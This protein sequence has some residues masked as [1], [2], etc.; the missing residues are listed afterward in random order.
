MFCVLWL[1]SALFAPSAYI[2]LFAVSVLLHFHQLPYPN[3]V[4]HFYR[5]F[6]FMLFSVSCDYVV[7]CPFCM[8]CGVYACFEFCV[9]CTSCVLFFF[10]V[11]DVYLVCVMLFVCFDHFQRFVG[12]SYLVVLSVFS[13]LP[14]LD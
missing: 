1:F 5:Y 13:R 11:R 3:L 7:F 8:F 6:N 4:T 2:A 14:L 9:F 12:G 10:L